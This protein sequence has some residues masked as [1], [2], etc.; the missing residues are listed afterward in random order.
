MGL[1]RSKK[2]GHIKNS[3]SES[4]SQA[5]TN[6][7]QTTFDAVSPYWSRGGSR[8]RGL[9]DYREEDDYIPRTEVEAQEHIAMI[10]E[11]KGLH[12][13][14]SNTADLQAALIV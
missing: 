2:L 3:A 14:D 5:E 10:R 6:Q 11:E 7:S 9:E 4:S 12:G 1:F 8:E 13:T